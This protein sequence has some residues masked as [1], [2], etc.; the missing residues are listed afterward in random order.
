MKKITPKEVEEIKKMRNLFPDKIIVEITRSED[1]GFCADIHTFPGCFTEADTFSELIE[2]VND[3]AKVYFNIPQK[4]FSF[5][6]DF[7]PPITEAQ[8]FK[9]FPVNLSQ[10]KQLTFLVNK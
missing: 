10:E 5:M 3:C 1:G 7:I 6:P 8:R 9:I 2:M 4:Y